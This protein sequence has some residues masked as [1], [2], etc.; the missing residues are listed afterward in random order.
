MCGVSDLAPDA[1][2]SAPE[3]NLLRWILDM[4]ESPLSRGR[5]GQ[6][7][8]IKCGIEVSVLSHRLLSQASSENPRPVAQ[9]L[10]GNP[11]ESCQ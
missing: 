1:K 3:G 11:L 4:G 2:V 6:S 5:W 7:I 8:W 10:L 9:E